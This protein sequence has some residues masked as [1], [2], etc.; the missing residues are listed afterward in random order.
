MN[1]EDL[2][3]IDELAAITYFVPDFRENPDVG[4]IL[5][6]IESAASR[7]AFIGAAPCECMENMVKESCFESAPICPECPIEWG[8]EHRDEETEADNVLRELGE[9]NEDFLRD[10]GLSESSIQ[11]ILS[12]KIKPSRMTI[13][14]HSRIILDDYGKQEIRL[15]DKTKALYFLFLRH[16]EGIAIKQLPEY[17]NELMD[18]YQSISG[19]DDP[20]AMQKTISDLVDP[21]QNFVNISL[22]RIKRAFGESFRRQIAEKYFVSGERG[23]VRK[24]ALDRNLITWE[25]IR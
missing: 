16:P 19:R 10:I 22:S 4:T 11:Y 5:S 8:T 20:Q 13:T 7:P 25:T 12:L 23:G 18:L 15:D 21:Y 1:I 3:D 17:L 9:M 6:E 2:L 14:R 24:V